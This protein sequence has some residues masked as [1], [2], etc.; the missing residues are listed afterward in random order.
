MEYLA[1][2][3]AKAVDRQHLLSDIIETIS[4]ELHLSINSLHT[5]T[6]DGIVTCNIKFFIHSYAE[7]QKIVEN[8]LAIPD[9]DEV[10]Y[11]N[12]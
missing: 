1:S 4:N 11:G 8:V 9:V 10:K 12:E 3:T 5:V 7:L 6:E 2:L